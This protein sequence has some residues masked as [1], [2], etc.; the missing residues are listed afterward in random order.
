MYRQPTFGGSPLISSPLME[1]RKSLHE[2]S[3]LLRFCY[4]LLGVLITT[5]VFIL[6]IA[7]GINDDFI[8]NRDSERMEIQNADCT[9]LANIYLDE[10]NEYLRI[11]EEMAKKYFD[12]KCIS[13]QSL[14][15]IP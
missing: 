11:S 10:E 1:L 13:N 2:A 15:V 14:E 9:T 5:G 7:L 4:C 3:S 8:D 6:F 12:V